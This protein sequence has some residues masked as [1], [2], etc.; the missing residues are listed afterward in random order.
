MLGCYEGGS[1]FDGPGLKTL[2]YGQSYS[3]GAITCDSDVRGDM[4]RHRH[5]HVELAQGIYGR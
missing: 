5:G 3:H 1:G 2:D 4:H